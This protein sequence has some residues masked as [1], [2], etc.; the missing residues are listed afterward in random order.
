MI[1]NIKWCGVALLVGVLAA[2]NVEARQ[3]WDDKTRLTFSEAVEVPGHVLPAGTYTFKLVDSNTNRHIVRILN[4][5]GSKVIATI[6][7]VS[8][9][10]LKVTDKTVIKFTE[11]PKGSP[12]A[13]RAW[14]YPGNAI[15]QEFVYSK[16]RAAQ[17]AK[18]SHEAVP[19]LTLD[20]TDETAMKTAALVEI[21]PDE[22]EMPMAEMMSMPAEKP[23]PVATVATAEP[24][25]R[26]LPHT[27]SSLPLVTLLGL[28]SLAFALCL[29]AFS[30]RAATASR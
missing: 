23:A 18:I 15:G 20:V 26:Q 14:F 5:D 13:I 16:H 11:M 12:E 6:M 22:K 9:Q 10:R 24:R 8:D 1:T 21:T 30:K 3:K 25:R 17:L 4:A 28:T 7:T 19:A 29:M 27:A 2:S